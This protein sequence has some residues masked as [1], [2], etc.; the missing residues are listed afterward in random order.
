[1]FLTTV[2]ANYQLNNG[3]YNAKIRLSNIIENFWVY[4]KYTKVD[5]IVYIYVC[6]YIFKLYVWSILRIEIHTQ[7]TF[8]PYLVAKI[9]LIAASSCLFC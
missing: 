3:I 6:I 8:V 5:Y 2:I 7:D 9:F 1:M 4:A